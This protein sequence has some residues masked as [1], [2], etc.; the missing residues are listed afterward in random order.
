MVDDIE[1]LTECVWA[2]YAGSALIA[3]SNDKE[4]ILLNNREKFGIPLDPTFEID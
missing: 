3:I 2:Q 1:G 4:G